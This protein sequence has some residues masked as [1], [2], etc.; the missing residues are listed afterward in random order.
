MNFSKRID[1]LELRLVAGEKNYNILRWVTRQDEDGKDGKEYCFVLAYFI[2]SSEG[3]DLKFVGPRPF[4]VEN[5]D[6]FWALIKYSQKVL[7]AEFDLEQDLK[8]LNR[9]KKE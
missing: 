3:Y 6:L 8:E 2:K 4:E 5:K 9:W 1:D 7:D